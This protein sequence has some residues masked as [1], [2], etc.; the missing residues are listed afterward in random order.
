MSPDEITIQALREAFLITKDELTKTRKLLAATSCAMTSCASRLA[1][2]LTNGT[3]SSCH[4]G[5]RSADDEQ[6]R[7]PGSALVCCKER[8]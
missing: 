2:P 3:L 8:G 6:Q 5:R 7:S 4:S 1:L